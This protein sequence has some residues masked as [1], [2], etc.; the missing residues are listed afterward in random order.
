MCM[1]KHVA[2]WSS[3]CQVLVEGSGSGRAT[4]VTLRGGGTIKARKVGRGLA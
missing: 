4:G 1:C 3:T 2:L